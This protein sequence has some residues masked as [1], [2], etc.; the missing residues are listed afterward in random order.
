MKKNKT[1]IIVGI[2]AVII[3]LIVIVGIVVF[4]RSNQKNRKEQETTSSEEGVDTIIEQKVKDTKYEM[5]ELRDATKFFTIEKYVQED[6]SLGFEA[7]KIYMAEEENMIIYVINGNRVENIEEASEVY[8]VLRVDTD[9]L[10]Y[11]LTEVEEQ[12]YENMKKG[13]FKIEVSRIEQNEENKF[14][15]IEPLTDRKLC[16]IYLNKFTNIELTDSKKAYEMLEEDCKKE[17]FPEYQQFENYVTELEKEMKEVEL[18]KY[19]VKEF[20]DYTEYIIQDSL[21][22]VYQ[23]KA[24]S[25]MDYTVKIN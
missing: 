8:Y 17:K 12:E 1:K 16:E 4:V 18:K 3:I 9:N 13:M 7:K 10:A 15:Y 23:L 24:K 6:T 25:V 11:M 21:D 14:A 19:E 22:H 2:V 20:D 5:T